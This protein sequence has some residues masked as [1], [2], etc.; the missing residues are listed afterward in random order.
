MKGEEY[1]N[2]IKP[3][4]FSCLIGIDIAELQSKI[5]DIKNYEKTLI[6]SK[7]NA[8]KS[9]ENYLNDLFVIRC[10]LSFFISYLEL[11]DSLY[12]GEFADSWDKLQDALDILRTIKKFS[13]IKLSF[14]E[15]QLLELEK[16]YPYK[17]FVSPGFFV[18][19]FE[20][21]ICN[22]DV[23]SPD[24]KHLAGE[25]YMG[26]LAKRIPKGLK[27]ID[28]IGF[29]ENPED[30]RFKVDIDSNESSFDI[31]RYISKMLKDGTLTP[32][33]FKEF[34]FKKIKRP[35][36]S[37]PQISRNE[38]CPCGSEIKYKRCCLNK[39][40]IKQDHCDI[41]VEK[42]ADIFNQLH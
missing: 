31:I 8:D 7:S 24:C 15:N 33:R 16:G 28:H 4:I 38:K 1:L 14:F 29:V 2:H 34:K 39:E 23:L 22:N 20:C 42:N 18:E 9:D 27:K 3:K 30:K 41:V 19:R 10:Y 12:K 25:L 6:E 40:Y 5:I 17:M 13:D 21:S 26:E 37:L 35:K 36:S 32:L 11:W